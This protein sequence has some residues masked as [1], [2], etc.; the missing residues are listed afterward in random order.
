LVIFISKRRNEVLRLEQEYAHKEAL[1][2]SYDSYRQQI[3]KLQQEQQNKL[4]PILL[5]K[6]IIAISLNPAET[7]D[8]GGKDKT[9]I[10]E[11][12]KKQE[13]L[14]FI[15]KAKDFSNGK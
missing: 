15:K 2:K 1:A 12:M 13:F 14:D 3:E 6:M 10:E 5:E 4:L 8:K 7:L 9:P 11:L